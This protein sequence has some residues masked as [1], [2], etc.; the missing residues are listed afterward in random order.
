[1]IVTS[2]DFL[3]LFSFLYIFSL[4]KFVKESILIRRKRLL[5]MMFHTF[6]KFF[7]FFW[8]I[9]HKSFSCINCPFEGW[10]G[11]YNFVCDNR[12]NFLKKYKKLKLEPAY[13]PIS[14]RDLIGVLHPHNNGT[15]APHMGWAPQCVGP[16]PYEGLLYYCCVSVV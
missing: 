11:Y 14:S 6:K 13:V 8:E 5:N 12:I 15:T 9:I 10:C 1:M 4:F 16:T 2:W 7:F 3:F